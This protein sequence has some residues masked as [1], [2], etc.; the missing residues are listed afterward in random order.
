MNWTSPYKTLAVGPCPSNDVL[1][2]KYLVAT[3]LYWT[4]PLFGLYFIF[5]TTR[6][7]SLIQE[8]KNTHDA[9][10]VP[11]YP[12]ADLTYNFNICYT[13]KSPPLYVSEDSI[14]AT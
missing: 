6:I 13:S 4:F 14:G 10:R 3:L 11:E 1:E 2:R 12:L 8:C 9:D 7:S 5:Q